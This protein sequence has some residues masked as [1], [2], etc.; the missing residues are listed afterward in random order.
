M[1]AENR[2]DFGKIPLGISSCL[3]GEEVRFDGGHKRDNYILGTLA[4]YFSFQP[5]CPEVAIGLSIP[6][7]PIRLVQFDD[8]IH[9]VGVKDQSIDVTDKM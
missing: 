8:G 7:P 1:S 9:V 3:L 6:R 2:D 4:D 5:V